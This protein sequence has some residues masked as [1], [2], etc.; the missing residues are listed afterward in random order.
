MSTLCFSVRILILGLFLNVRYGANA[1]SLMRNEG[2]S[3]AFANFA[4]NS[5]HY[6]NITPLMQVMVDAFEEC[7]LSCLQHNY[8]FSFNVAAFSDIKKQNTLCELVASD[9]FKESHNFVASQQHHHFSITTPCDNEPCKNGATCL[10]KYEDNSYDCACITG[11]AGN[12]CETEITFHW[13]LA[14]TDKQINLRGAAM[15][16]QQDG[17]TVLFL[18][19]SPGTFAETPAF[20]IRSKNLTIAVWIK[21]LTRSNQPVYGDWSAPFSFR[22]F[23]ANG[24]FRLQVRDGNGR[25]LLT[26]STGGNVVPTNRWSHIAITWNRAYRRA[27][28]FINGEKKQEITVAQDKNVDFMD[29]GHSV[30]DIGLKRDSG[31][32]AHAYFSDLMVFNREL[33]FSPSE[34][35]NEI[36]SV[37]FLTHPLHNFV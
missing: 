19:G 26:P 36:K 31:T 14:G 34:N 12:S 33:Q 16:I 11:Y 25:D 30:Y 20:P 29:S 22:L 18:N 7:G 5:F 1:T 8:C 17:Q 32:V 4:M 24:P 10:A 23:V 27:R 28:L 35:V 2:Q 6:L 37:I 3:F 15:F 9:K 13:K 21:L